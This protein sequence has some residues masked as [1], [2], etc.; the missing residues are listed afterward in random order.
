MCSVTVWSRI[1]EWLLGHFNNQNQENETLYLKVAGA[2]EMIPVQ[3]D[4][5]YKSMKSF[6]A[7]HYM[8]YSQIYY[9]GIV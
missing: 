5:A 3:A 2:V 9:Q 7:I 6:K 8:I 1:A 4:K